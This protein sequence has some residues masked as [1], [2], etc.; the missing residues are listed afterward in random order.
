M[1][2]LVGENEP[3]TVSPELRGET[4]FLIQP[5]SGVS[6]TVGF[7]GNTA[8]D[9]VNVDKKKR[10][11]L[12][13]N[14]RSISGQTHGKAHILQSKAFQKSQERPCSI[15]EEK[16]TPNSLNSF[17]AVAAT[18]EQSGRKCFLCCL[19]NVF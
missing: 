15:V 9:W 18:Q 17:F 11:F 12:V 8:H 19:R 2:I 5:P 4:S 1:D 7:Y 16:W 10:A 14:D 3:L 13:H 6:E